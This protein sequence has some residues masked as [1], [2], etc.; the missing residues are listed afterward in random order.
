MKNPEGLTGFVVSKNCL[1]LDYCL[2]ECIMSLLPICDEIVVGEM[3]SDDGT[4]EFLD[5]W[6]F[7]QPRLNVVSIRDW[8][9]ERGSMTWYTSALN[10]A[11]AHIGFSMAIGLDADEVLSDDPTTLSIVR[12]AVKEKRAIALDRLN[13]VRDAHS[14][15][16]EGE[17]CGKYVVRV[18]PSDLW[19]PSDEPH[20][21]GEVPLL[22]MANIEPAAKIF[23]L[24]FLR[25]RDAFYSKAR[26]VLGAFFNEFDQRLKRSE[27]SGAHPFEE[28]PWWNRLNT[29]HG[30]YPASVR[31]WMRER[32]YNA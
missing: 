10:E 27:L 19:W 22:D 26:V 6:S 21:P 4:R 24:G 7:R 12:K 16:P 25:K 17:C 28:F 18:G 20:K 9:K 14:L 29:Y 5:N 23:H 8:T 32:G 1:S 30:Y 13:F 15:I 11:R 31:A 2:E 3:G